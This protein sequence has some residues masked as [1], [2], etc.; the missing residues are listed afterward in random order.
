MQR[1][2]SHY[3]YTFQPNVSENVNKNAAIMYNIGKPLFTKK[4]QPH[5]MQIISWSANTSSPK[6]LHITQ[7]VSSSSSSL[8]YMLIDDIS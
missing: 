2:T 4:G 3:S 5:S 1:W 6:D 7:S 8:N